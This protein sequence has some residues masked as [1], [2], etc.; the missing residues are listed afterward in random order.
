[1]LARLTLLALLATASLPAQTS[2][3]PP[4]TV[5]VVAPAPATGSSSYTLPGRTEPVESARVFTRATGIVESRAF[6]IGDTVKA[7]DTLAVIAAPDLDRSVEAALATLEQ[8]EVLAANARLLA[9]RSA[10]LR[11]SDTISQE[12]FDDRA[13]AA[14]AAEASVRVARAT[15]E[16]LREQ[17][18]FATV[19]APFDAV[20]VARNFDRGDR[21]RGDAATSEGWLYHLAR[22]DTLRFVVGAT[23][24]LALRLTPG[25]AAIVR[26]NEFP[27]RAY[28]AKVA[29]TSRVFDNTSGTMRVELLLENADLALPAGL[30]GNVTFELPPAAGA[31]L[32]P[33]NALVTRAGRG[34]LATVRDG[35]VAFLEV[36]PGRNLGPRIEVASA[37]L[38]ADTQIITNPNAMLRPGD[39]VAIEA[40]K[41][42]TPPPR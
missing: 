42:A 28:P 20:V 24:D 8:A 34:T 17:Q 40:P 4:P 11:A 2:A 31:W 30:T 27:G 32:V 22:L 10:E 3:P 7:G 36:L 15:L 14:A 9:K 38:A 39:P 18:N 37:A 23:P 35:K 26:F 21:V 33:T 25:S 19:R 29:R 6:D 13:A 5:R 41:S 16:R 12:A 1:M